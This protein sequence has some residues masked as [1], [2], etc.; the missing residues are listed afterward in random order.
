MTNSKTFTFGFWL[1]VL[2][3][4]FS[5]G[6][7]L[8]PFFQD[9]TEREKN[10]VPFIGLFFLLISGSQLWRDAKRIS[11]NPYEKTI[12]FIHLFTR[13]V[14]IY[15]FENLEGYVDLY[16]PSKGG[17]YRVLYLVKGNKYIEKISTF[18]YSNVDE[19]ESEIKEIKYLGLQQFSYI[20]SIKILFRQDVFIEK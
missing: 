6:L 4:L 1:C 2:L 10:I 13:K 14:T 18:I 5:I 8:S 11:I 17:S 16:Q 9:S 19:M 3:T 7:G 20:K 12:T 15:N